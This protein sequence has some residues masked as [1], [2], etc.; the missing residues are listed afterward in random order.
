VAYKLLFSDFDGTLTLD[1]Q[2]TVEFFHILK[3]ANEL[4]TPLVVVTGRSVQWAYFVL[5]HFRELTHFIAEGGGVSVE[6]D[7][8]GELITSLAI[9]DSERQRLEEITGNLTNHFGIEL[10]ADSSGRLTDRAVELEVFRKNPGLKEQVELFLKKSG[11]NYSTSNVHLNFW[12]GE[13]SKA[14]A[15]ESFLAQK[16]ASLSKEEVLFFGDSLNDESVFA[17]FPHTVGV[18]NIEN[19][20]SKLASKPAVKLEGIENKGPKGVLNYLRSLK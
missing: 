15:M 8:H 18:S 4:N 2:L 9:T 10:S 13:I 5:T 11:A 6:R 12:V 1:E 3:A 19:V 7:S 20:W 16:F 17:S 14:K